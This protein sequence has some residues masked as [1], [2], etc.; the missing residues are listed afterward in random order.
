ETVRRRIAPVLEGRRFERVEI[1]DPRLVRPYEPEAVAAELT[2]ERVAAVDRRGKYLIV[3]FDSGRALLIHLRMTGSLRS[4]D[5]DPAEGDPHRRAVVRLDNGSDVAYRDVRRFGTWLLLEPG[6]LDPYLAQKVGE[7]PLDALFTAARLG[8][9]LERRRA[10]IKAALLDQRSRSTASSSG[11]ST[12]RSA[13]RSRRGSRGRGRRSGTTAFP[14]ASPEPCSTS[15][16]C[17][18]GAASRA[19]GAGRRS[20]SRASA[21]A[22]PGSARRVSRE[23]ARLRRRG[24]RRAGRLGRGARARCSRRS[25]G[26][27]SGSAA[28]SSRRSAPA[29]AGGSGD[30]RRGRSPRRGDPSS[31]GAPSRARSTR[32]SGSCTSRSSPFLL[33]NAE[34]AGSVPRPPRRPGPARR[35]DSR[36]HARPLHHDRGGRPPVDPLRRGRPRPA[37]LHGRPGPRRGGREGRPQDEVA[38]RGAARAA[39][40]RRARPAPRLRRARHDHE[41]PA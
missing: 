22:A 5:G 37:P 14:T 8:A 23:R 11:A 41:R 17:T 34:A 1:H 12:R 20:R 26:R 32:T 28:P 29:G 38:L 3:R 10:P 27:R 39:L 7:E 31:R 33:Y 24:A 13:R 4:Y 36:S 18:G 19:T 40:A 9:K 25:G 2:G 15:S 30:R 35:L 16:R 21:A 6:E